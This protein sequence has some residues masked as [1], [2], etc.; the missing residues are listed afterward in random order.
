MIPLKLL[1]ELTQKLVAAVPDNLQQIPAELQHN[2]HH[3]LQ[4]N[5][6]KL[7]L[8]PADEFEVQSKVLART[9]EKVEQL[10]QQVAILEKKMEEKS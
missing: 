9:R 4:S 2:F 1:D 8:V 6:R 7:N 5:L 3:I 10:T